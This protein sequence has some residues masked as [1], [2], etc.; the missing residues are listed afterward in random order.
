MEEVTFEVGSP[1]DWSIFTFSTDKRTC[2]KFD[3]CSIPFYTYIFQKMGIRLPL[4]SFMKE[5]L[6]HLVNMEG[7]N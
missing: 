6:D 5:V 4:A 7:V 2:R 3:G 1:S